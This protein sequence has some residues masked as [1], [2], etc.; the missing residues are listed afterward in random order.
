ME[1]QRCDRNRKGTEGRWKY[2]GRESRQKCREELREA[3][4]IEVKRER[5][6]GGKVVMESGGEIRSDAARARGRVPWPGSAWWAPGRRAGVGG[7]AGVPS[8]ASRSKCSL[9]CPALP[10]P[11][12][13]E[14]RPGGARGFRSLCAPGRESSGAPRCSRQGQGAHD[15]GQGRRSTGAR[16]RSSLPRATANPAPSAGEERKAPGQAGAAVEG[17]AQPRTSAPKRS[18]HKSAP[19]APTIQWPSSPSGAPF[20]CSPAPVRIC[21]HI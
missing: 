6:R 14:P 18:R 8:Q 12:A 11:G 15:T 20:P 5:E 13:R 1:T 19:P 4:E 3:M 2:R 17:G 9:Q 7:H 10:A 16:A 21:T